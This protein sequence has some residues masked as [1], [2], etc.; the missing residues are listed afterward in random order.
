MSGRRHLVAAFAAYLLLAI[1]ATWPLAAR[2]AEHV[3]GDEALQGMCVGTPNLNVWAL[4]FVLHQLPRDPLHLF[5]ANAFPPYP[6]T[7]A[8]SE[9][10]FVPAL[11]A[12]PFLALTGNLVFAYN[13]TS[14]LTLALA[15]LGMYLLARELVG[16]GVGAFAAG[17]LYAFHSF[18]VNELIRLQILS[19]QW[20]PFLVLALVRFFKAPSG[21]RA[22]AVGAAYALQSL[23]CMYWLL[24]APFVAAPLV[25]VLW[26]RH[27]TAWRALLPV[28]LA[29]GV[30]LGLSGLFAWPYLQNEHDFGFE[31]SSVSSMPPDRYGYVLPNNW[32]YSW[33]L[34]TTMPNEHAPHFIGFLS[35]A[36]AAAGL[37]RMRRGPESLRRVAP[38]LLFLVVFGLATSLGPDMTFGSVSIPGPYAFLRAY[39]PGFESSRYPERFSILALL[40][41]APFVAAGLAG[42]AS[43]RAA[44]GLL[45][46]LVFLEHLAPPMSLAYLPSREH[47]PEVYRWLAGQE[48]VKVVAHVPA[49]RY[50]G[51]RA[52]GI[53]MYLSTFHWKRT[54][55][56]YTGY[57]P[58]N[59]QFLKWHLYNFPATGDATLLAKAGIDT[60]V[61][62]PGTLRGRSLEAGPW[63]QLGPFPG[64][65]VVLRLDRVARLPTTGPPA[66]RPSPRD[67]W[68]VSGSA[69]GAER[70]LD[71]S[72]ATAWVGNS[73]RSIALASYRVDFGETLRVRRIRIGLRP[74][75]WTFPTRFDVLGLAGGTEID[76][77]LDKAAIYGRLLDS[78]MDAP[79][80]PAMIIEIPPSELRGLVLEQLRPDLFRMPWSIAEFDVETAP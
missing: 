36:L 78:L 7:L 15:G 22:A 49:S 45:A 74:G 14:L 50:F 19:N 12:A 48:D 24:Y 66:F 44:S 53:P 26:W 28:G 43:S 41:L 70:T 80:A 65:E 30:A 64:G 63:T 57:F 46:A 25:A 20:F 79:L 76:M 6:R 69:P 40:G 13:M 54:V 51:E 31:R 17:A 37:W 75:S 42:L 18:N 2:S 62:E 38:A 56:G 71:G 61:L 16:D 32:M 4:G 23:S 72:L 29:L 35:L 9:H 3:V 21:R 33:L 8:F 67:H 47:V 68:R 52:D 10:L 73:L 77:P 27:R 34:P 60:L 11:L 1:L 59:Y 39:V 58:P 55:Q 5:D